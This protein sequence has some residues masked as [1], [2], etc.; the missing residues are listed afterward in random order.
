MQA[1][2]SLL[3]RSESELVRQSESPRHREGGT[4]VGSHWSHDSFTSSTSSVNGKLNGKNDRCQ[5]AD[6]QMRLVLSRSTRNY[7]SMER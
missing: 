1:E 4:A 6:S 7:R 5:D 3:F 2:G